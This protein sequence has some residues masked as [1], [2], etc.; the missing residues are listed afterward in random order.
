MPILLRKAKRSSCHGSRHN[1]V[2]LYFARSDTGKHC[3]IHGATPGGPAPVLLSGGAKFSQNNIHHCVL[4]RRKKYPQ[5]HSITEKHETQIRKYRSRQAPGHRPQKLHNFQKN[6]AR[7]ILR[8]VGS[9]AHQIWKP[10]P[11]AL[12]K[13]S[14][15]RNHHSVLEPRG[16]FK[17]LRNFC[18]PNRTDFRTVVRLSNP[19]RCSGKRSNN[20]LMISPRCRRLIWARLRIVSNRMMLL[21][22]MLCLESSVRMDRI[23]AT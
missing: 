11:W 9:R 4:Q 23:I 6:F 5:R 7:P 21:L 10:S 19:S 16:F 13:L 14:C 22:K 20:N 12:T 1:F 15:N 3:L 18:T 2:F 17:S 8:P